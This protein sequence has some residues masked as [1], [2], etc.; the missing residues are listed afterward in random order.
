MPESSGTPTPALA[1]E[2]FSFLL[3]GGSAVATDMGTYFLL[4]LWL[5]HAPAKAISF[6]LGSG[7]AYILNKIF[8]FRKPGRSAAEV[9]RFVILYT[10]TLGANV[11][12]N[13]A[14][15]LLSLPELLAFLFATGTSTVLNYLGQKFWVFR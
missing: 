5:S 10:M 14:C 12:V 1:R 9:V 3:A 15:L 8:T 11:L 7:V 6:I 2:L 4:L 13:Q